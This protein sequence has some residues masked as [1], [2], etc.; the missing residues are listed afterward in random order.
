MTVAALFVQTGGAYYD[1]FDV[2]PW[3]EARDA[4]AYA[5]PWAVVAHPPC[6]R[7][8]R[9]AAL[10]ETW[11]GYKR[12]DDGGCFA[13]AL[14]AVRRFGGVLEHPAYSAA[15]SR[16]GLPRPTTPYGWTSS[17]LDDG[18]SC[19]VEQGRYGLPTKKPTWL[20][21]FGVDDLPELRWGFTP[22]ILDSEHI[23][24]NGRGGMH[25]FRNAV[26]KTSASRT[27]TEFR[28]VLLDM[29]RSALPSFDILP[30]VASS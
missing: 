22:P 18:A 2:D 8:S 7:W 20:Y 10:T 17:L 3:D 5:G 16:F 28:D 21:A 1:L 26:N 14:A 25:A 27:P 23:D 24:P 12:G 30:A 13:A 19:Y 15:W 29:A 9:T 11:F 4:R 6:A